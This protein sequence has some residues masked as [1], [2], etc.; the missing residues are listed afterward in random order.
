MLS[1]VMFLDL[2]NVSILITSEMIN[3]WNPIYLRN[4][5]SRGITLEECLSYCCCCSVTSDSLQLQHTRHPCPS[6]T[7]RACLNSCLLSWWWHPSI[8]SLSSPSPPAFNLSQHQGLFQWV[9]SLHWVAKVLEL[10]HQ[11]FQW[12]FRV[13]FL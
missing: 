2:A 9:S 13:D 4:S 7:P 11:S 12:I 6:P 1:K 8:S 5:S 3:S 10:Q